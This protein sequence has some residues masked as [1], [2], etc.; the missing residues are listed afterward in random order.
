[1]LVISQMALM[2][3]AAL[4]S[5]DLA[6]ISVAL[7][8][9]STQIHWVTGFVGAILAI[10]IGDMALWALGRF[11]GRKALT[12]GWI[13]RR[14]PAARLEA[15]SSWFDRN[16]LTAMIAARFVPGMRL[17]MYFAS[18]IIG[19]NIAKVIAW[20]FIASLIWAPLFVGVIALFGE[21]VLAPIQR[22]L[23]GGW[24]SL[25]LVASLVYACFVAVGR[26]ASR[27]GRRAV[28]VMVGRVHR[29]EFW[30]SWLFYFP[31][32][33]Y[34]LWLSLRYRGLTTFTAANP[35]IPAGGVVDES[36]AQI[37]AQLPERF[38]ADFTLIPQGTVPARLSTLEGII[39]ARHWKFPLFLKPDNGYRGASVKRIESALEA[40]RY[41]ESQPGPVV[42]QVAHPG[43]FE[44]GVF[45]YRLPNH[46]HGHI[47][48]ITDK[49]F[50]T[51]VGDGRHTVEELIWKHPRFFMQARVFLRRH[52]LIRH[53]VLTSG[54][55]LPLAVAG[56]HCQGTMFRDGSHLI[57][58]A[59]ESRMDEIAHH[60][61]GFFFGR[62]D[63]RYSDPDAFMA[64]NDIT[65]IELNGVTSESTNLYDPTW[66]I[67]RAYRTLAASWRLAFAIGSDNRKVGHQPT[68]LVELLNSLWKHFRSPKLNPL[69]D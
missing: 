27:D 25:A 57:T 24:V 44:A 4:I 46:S 35:G 56:N 54:E 32:I 47:F 2:I 3:G 30:P 28:R 58:P 66:S 64:G 21:P 55:A 62:F 17:P 23:G 36:K 63:I 41:L 6:L 15:A 16:G 11:V 38:V 40:R 60:F 31:M 14:L 39:Q 1:M 29:W 65:I 12:F 34:L 22:Y 53:R 61:A 42:A 19:R 8:I 67:F 50:S 13:A 68:R 18:G 26:F 48:S 69:S 51:L 20:T 33:P 59:L 43:P 9:R 10:F 45:Y 37:L 5:E 49:H 52:H 7:L